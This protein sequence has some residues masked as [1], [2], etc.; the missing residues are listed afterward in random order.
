VCESVYAIL[1]SSRKAINIGT[2][3]QLAPH[4]LR[5]GE[6][7]IG[8]HSVNTH[9]EVCICARIIRVVLYVRMYISIRY[10]AL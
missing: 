3:E 8:R 9:A 4:R 10:I 1:T 7:E 2:N 5:K 6:K